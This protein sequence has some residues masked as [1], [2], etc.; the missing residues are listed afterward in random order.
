[1]KNIQGIGWNDATFGVEGQKASII[2]D[3][4]D[5]IISLIDY[6]HHSY[7]LNSAAMKFKNIDKN[8]PDVAE[9]E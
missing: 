8:M 3:L 1:M 6:G 9:M 4:T 5:K 2:D 7:W